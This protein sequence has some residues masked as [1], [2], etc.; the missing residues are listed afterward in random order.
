[1]LQEK[2]LGN[3]GADAAGSRKPKQS[4]D[5]MNEE[6]KHVAH[7]ACYQNAE[8]RRNSPDLSA[9]RR[10]ATSL[11]PSDGM[12]KWALLLLSEEKRCRSREAKLL[13]K[14]IECPQSECNNADSVTA[15]EQDPVA[16]M[17]SKGTREVAQ[18][19]GEFN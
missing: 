3:D 19:T 8:N 10:K 11:A 16:L 12:A 6:D 15:W 7:A 14:H 4:D 18:K 2:R 13:W 5:D 17:E 1:M 9:A